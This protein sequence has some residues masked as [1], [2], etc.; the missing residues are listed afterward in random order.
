LEFVGRAFGSGYIRRMEFIPSFFEILVNKKPLKVSNPSGV[1]GNEIL[2]VI[3][4]P[5]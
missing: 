2:S 4:Q 1:H 3:S 5:H